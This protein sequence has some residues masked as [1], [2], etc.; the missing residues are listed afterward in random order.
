MATGACMYRNY[1]DA[2]IMKQLGFHA[3]M[4][5][6]SNLILLSLHWIK[7]GRATLQSFDPSSIHRFWHNYSQRSALTRGV[8]RRVLAASVRVRQRCR[9]Y[10]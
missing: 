2:V 5:V 10:S 4:A 9:V 7:S 1:H 6:L 3:S 8:V